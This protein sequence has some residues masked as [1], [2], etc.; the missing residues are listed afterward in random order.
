MRLVYAARR[1]RSTVSIS[2]ARVCLAR[3][4]RAQS[5]CKSGASFLDGIKERGYPRDQRAHG[6]EQRRRL[7]PGRLWEPG[8]ESKLGPRENCADECAF[9]I[10]APDDAKGLLLFLRG[11][12]WPVQ[13]GLEDRSCDFWKVRH[14]R[15]SSSYGKRWIALGLAEIQRKQRKAQEHGRPS[16]LKS[17][18]T[19]AWW[20]VLWNSEG[21]CWEPICNW[22]P[23][24][25]WA[26]TAATLNLWWARTFIRCNTSGHSP[27]CSTTCT[28]TWT[29][30]R[31]R[32]WVKERVTSCWCWH[33]VCLYMH[34]MNQ[35]SQLSGHVYAT[36]AS[37]DGGGACQ[38]AGS[39]QRAYPGTWSHG[40]GRSRCWS[41]AGGGMLCRD[42]DRRFEASI[43]PLGTGA[44][45]ACWHWQQCWMWQGLQATLP[46]C[47]LVQEHWG[48]HLWRGKRMAETV[49]QGNQGD[50]QWRLAM[51]QPQPTESAQRWRWSDQQPA[52]GQDVRSEDNVEGRVKTCGPAEPTSESMSECPICSGRDVSPQHWSNQLDM[53]SADGICLE[54][55]GPTY[56]CAGDGF[57]PWS[58][59]Q[60]GAQCEVP[61]LPNGHLGGQPSRSERVD[62]GTDIC[63]SPAVTH[64]AGVGCFASLRSAGLLRLDQ[65]QLEPGRWAVPLGAA[66]NSCLT[67]ALCW[68][69]ARW[70][71]EKQT[72]G[73]WAL[74]RVWLWHLLLT[75]DEF[76]QLH[77]YG[78]PQSF[79]TLDTK[80]LWIRW[81]F[82]A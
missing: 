25:R 75:I 80:S 51:H 18:A 56:Q 52:P 76:L 67:K 17:M 32:W 82:V 46:A 29:Q 58:A 19:M 65:V 5:H 59:A 70:L 47:S 61:Q 72:D 68:D 63:K 62:Q 69:D 14:L 24:K 42:R 36:D 16:A 39:V 79:S 12:L 4:L 9:P 77:G 60:V 48:H 33:W 50:P 43:G 64:P 35:K 7:H 34:W 15:N 30:R 73:P 81:I 3:V 27:A 11:Q 55:K 54:T 38:S 2:Q 13:G 53:E 20:E 45:G 6:M 1:T 22:L 74:C 37:E 8:N 10:G 71:S 23:R 31:P 21:R 44:D 41:S 78:Y 26:T 66:T 28:W 57:C 40:S 49:C